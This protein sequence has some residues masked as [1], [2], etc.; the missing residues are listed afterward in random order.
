M[1]KGIHLL[2]KFFDSDIET[3]YHFFFALKLPFFLFEGLY[4]NFFS[5]DFAFKFRN[6]IVLFLSKSFDGVFLLFGDSLDD[7]FFV[8]LKNIFDLWE[9]GFDDLSHSAE[10]LKE[11]GNLFLQGWTKDIWY[12]RLHRPYDTLDVFLVSGVLSYETALEFH[13]GLNDELKLINFGF[14]F[15]WYDFVVFKNLGDYWVQLRE[16]FRELGFY[17]W[18]IHQIFL[19]LILETDDCSLMDFEVLFQLRPWNS[20]AFE[21]IC[22]LCKFY[23]NNYNYEYIK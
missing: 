12:F 4:L 3:S 10:A 1:C 22:H 16:R 11:C 2:L 8:G 15:I 18:D 7:V 9:V 14:F 6:L 23:L 13:Y 21:V 20:F 19:Q 17:L 5:L